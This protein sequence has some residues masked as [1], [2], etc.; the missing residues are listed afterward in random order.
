MTL[1]E[2]LAWRGFIN[3]TTFKDIKEL[4]NT[5]RTFYWGVDPSSSSMTIGNLAAAMMA[6]V[7]IKHN[8]KPVLLVGGATGLI[9]D[10]DGKAQ[11]RN[12]KTTEEVTA[13]KNA[14]IDQYKIIFN[15]HDFTVVDNYDWFKS[16]GYLEF[17]RVI[18]KHVP[19]RQMLA[20]EFVQSRLSENGAG[21]SYAEFSYSLIQGYDFL[22]L[23][24][25][26]GVTLQ[27][28]GAD[29]WGNSIAG[30]D[31]IRRKTGEEAHVWTTPLVVN[32]STG[33]K[34]GKTE[35]GAVWIDS[36]K[37]S[38]YKFYQFWLNADDEGV[39]DYLKIYTE[40]GKPEVESVMKDFNSDKSQ[41]TAQKML[42]YEVT[43]LIHGQEVADSVVNITKVLFGEND[44]SSLSADDFVQLKSELPLSEVSVG[45]SVVS[46]VVEAGLA[47]SNSQARRFAQQGAIYINGKSVAPEYLFSKNDLID[48]SHAIL[49][50]GKNSNAVV[51]I[52][53]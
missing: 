10:P 36:K 24:E 32:K 52:N 19:M 5:K 37:T 29:Q 46:A 34:F 12:L 40:L 44:Y 51:Q 8:Y 45:D 3:Q 7:F 17:L 48:D 9:G 4:D 30:V 13:N 18:G 11:E 21:I 23:F 42:A 6:K 27:L 53:H 39:E 49:R 14:I 26:H 20:R 15:G 38:P 31:L 28:S 35:D 50:R 25:K 1:S 47:D 2:E 43:K 33:V 22:H 16:I 41:R